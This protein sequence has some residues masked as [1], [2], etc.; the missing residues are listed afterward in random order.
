MENNKNECQYC[1][2][3][4]KKDIYLAK[5]QKNAKYCVIIQKKIAEKEVEKSIQNLQTVKEE[6][7]DEIRDL[8]NTNGDLIVNNSGELEK[9][10]IDEIHSIYLL[11]END[12]ILVENEY[13]LQVSIILEKGD[14]KHNLEEYY[15]L[16]KSKI[17]KLQDIYSQFENKKLEIQKKYDS[18][19]LEE[20][21]YEE[22][23]KFK[24]KKDT[25][26]ESF[27]KIKIKELENTFEK[28]KNKIIILVDDVK[29]IEN[30]E[31]ILNN[32]IFKINKFL[33]FN[34]NISE[35]K[36]E[37]DA[38]D[39]NSNISEEKN[40]D[41][42]KESN[43]NISYDSSQNSKNNLKKRKQKFKRENEDT[44][45]KLLY[46]LI[47]LL[48][49]QKINNETLMYIV[50]E[51]MKYMNNYQ[52]KGKDK[53]NSIL[54]ILKNF[55]NTNNNDISNKEDILIFIDKF[56]DEFVNIIS[57]IS[58]KKIRIKQKASCFIPLFF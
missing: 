37:D 44:E 58:D 40:E 30:I 42:V 26:K 39:S 49:D 29:D 36:N 56:L 8:L 16:E 17:C 10:K 13:N 14:I 22:E 3:T 28:I 46:H 48:Q 52:I 34:D 23:E 57:A 24:D 15:T 7:N 21:L 31:E 12:K 4:F 25:W 41:D 50:V 33:E 20:K 51:L 38:K 5:H 18:V 54:F 43:S 2:K 27:K 53:K 35:E 11:A 9:N 1:K 55:I 19:I 47:L 45:N 6:I 32:K